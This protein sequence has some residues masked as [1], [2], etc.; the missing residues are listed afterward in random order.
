MNISAWIKAARPRT[1]P[2]TLVCI[3]TGNAAASFFGPFSWV[4]FGLTVTTAFLLQ[5]LSNFANDYGDFVKGTDN[6]NRVGPQR[7]MQS[8]VISVPQMKRALWICAGLSLLSGTGLLLYALDSWVEWMIFFLMGLFSMAAA[9]MY[10]VGKKAYGYNGLGDLMVFIF[11]G[12]V[13][14]FGSYYLQSGTVE[15]TVFLPAA[16]VGLF[17]AGVLNMNNLRDIDNDR[18]SG[19]NTLAVMLGQANTKRYQ[20]FLIMAG[21]SCTVLFF[22][23]NNIPGKTVILI[24][25]LLL[26]AIHLVAVFR[27]Q[28]SEGFDKHLK[29]CVFSTLIYGL[30]FAVAVL[31]CN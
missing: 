19:K 12:L 10:T 18:N 27:E 5:V 9:V 7:A 30:N 13:G 20:A 21:L 3:G 4:I 16:S 23:I 26:F 28:K 29:I 8:G 1:L 2:L 11:F 14:V 31:S 24:P 25:S 6:E 22:C 15:W 17:S